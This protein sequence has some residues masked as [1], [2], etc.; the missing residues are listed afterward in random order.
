MSLGGSF[1]SALN[2]AVEAAI[3]A[4]VLFVVAA[5]NDN[6]DA[7][8]YSPA[9]SPS[10]VSVCATYTDQ[11]GSAQSDERATFSNFGT[12]THILAPGQMIDSAWIGSNTASKT[13]SGTSMASP[14]VCGLAALYLSTAPTTSPAA[15]K[16]WLISASSKNIV[17]LQCT[18]TACKNT[19]NNFLHWSC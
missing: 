18:S 19:P 4:G 11:S 5:G 2:N 6:A 15:L 16:A 7:C 8:N 9:S 17:D 14:H 1:S 13:I 10:A 3:K 12:C